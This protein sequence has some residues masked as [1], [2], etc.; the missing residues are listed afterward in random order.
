VDPNALI[1]SAG[2]APTSRKD[3]VA[4]PDLDFLRGMYAAGAKPYFDLLGA[5]GAGY[6]VP[7]DTDPAGSPKIP[8]STTTTPARKTA[9]A[10]TASA[11]SRTSAR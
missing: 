1:V 5:H 3:D 9:N 4:M 2:L 10:S 11:T 7:P 6:K 8:R